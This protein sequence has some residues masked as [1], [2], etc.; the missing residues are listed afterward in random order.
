VRLTEN[1]KIPLFPFGLAYAELNKGN[2]EKGKKILQTLSKKENELESYHRNELN[3]LKQ[4][5]EALT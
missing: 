2:I 5:I 1:P 3:R 4:K